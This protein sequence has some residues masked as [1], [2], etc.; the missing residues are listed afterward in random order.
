MPPPFSPVSTTSV[1]DQQDFVLLAQCRINSA[2]HCVSLGL[3][4]HARV[5]CLMF[6]IKPFLHKACRESLARTG[7]LR[8][9]LHLPVWWKICT[10]T[11][12]VCVYMTVLTGGCGEGGVCL[13]DFELMKS[14]QGFRMD[15]RQIIP[16]KSS[17]WQK[18]T[19]LHLRNIEKQKDIIFLKYT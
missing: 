15:E 2:A 10:V 16:C 5:C 18:E 4:R 1:V 6:Y 9:L 7:R 11:V 8:Y 13:Q 12:C 14:R 17:G 19:N 3:C